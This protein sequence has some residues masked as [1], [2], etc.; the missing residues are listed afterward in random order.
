MQSRDFEPIAIIGMG[1]RFPGG[2]NSPEAFWDLLCKGT[3][4]IVD[5]PSDRWDVRRFY[6][7]DP[8]KPGKTYAKQGGFLRE[9]IDEFDPLFFGISPREAESM[10]PQQ[11]LLLEV[12][13]EA[14]EDA[15]V[16]AEKLEGSNTGVF[17]GGFCLDNKLLRFN[18][19]NLESIDMH[20]AA[21]SS[22]T[23]LSN[24]ISYIYDL[25]GPS[26]TIDTACSSSLVAT[27]YACHSIW[28]GE[29]EL[30]IA[31][32]AN[33]ML[34][35]EFG[36]VMSKGRFLSE[37]SRCMAFD[38]RA[39][40][41][42]RGE[43][44]GVVILKPL[45]SALTDRD[46][47]H[48][49]IRMSGVN[50]DGRTSGI[51]LPNALAQEELIRNV[52]RRAGISPAEVGYIEAHGTGTQVG[53]LSEITALNAA[54]SDDRDPGSKCFVGSVK[55]NIG[56]LE[57]A[58]G[59]AG[60]IKTVLCLKHRKIPPNLHFEQ[61]NPKIHFE[62]FC[63]HVP[64]RLEKWTLNSGSAYA[65]VNSF[66]YGGTNA[67]VVVEEAPRKNLKV[68]R[69][70]VGEIKTEIKGK[71]LSAE[72]SARSRTRDEAGGR[73]YL[74]P[75]SARS[76]QALQDLAGKYAFHLME[77][78]ETNLIEDIA[79]TASLKRTHFT[80][81]LAV[82]A[83]TGEELRNK[84][85]DFSSGEDIHGYVMGKAPPENQ[86]RLAS[87]YTGMGPQWWGM[88]REL[89]QAETVFRETFLKVDELFSELA[90]W[91]IIQAL[92]HN[93]S[94]SRISQTEV[95]QPANL[96]LQIALTALWKSWGITPDAVV[97]HSV[98]EVAAAY[99]AGALSLEDAV[100]VSFHRSRLQQTMAGRGAMLA[101]GLSERETREHI[102]KYADLSIA[103][104][105]SQS[106]VTVSGAPN[107]LKSLADTLE[108]NGAFHRSLKV[109]VAYHSY[110]MDALKEDF[111]LAL[112]GLT[113]R[114]A[115]FPL[116]STVTGGVVSGEELTSTYWWDNVRQPVRFQESIQSILGKGFRIFLEVGPHPVLGTSIKEVSA[117]ANSAVTT[118]PSLRRQTS[119]LDEI[120]NSLGG[121]FT[122]GFNIHWNTIAPENGTF[123]TL[124]TYA[125]Q[126]ERFW[127]ETSKSL[128]DRIG[129]NDSAF[130]NEKLG[131]PEPAWEVEVKILGASPEAFDIRL[132]ELETKQ[133]SGN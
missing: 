112:N 56:H 98:G 127:R 130:F 15:G 104:I 129:N 57:A 85:L 3:D 79:Y 73:S 13:W 41:Y 17:I 51:S 82:V 66:G 108:R 120:L 78:G 72:F 88:G 10:D 76:E 55:T 119:E 11:R 110:Q 44:A 63:V 80:H 121:L 125:W 21:S 47:I 114:K 61:P 6:D 36:I 23:I 39:T 14:F 29:S 102:R 12:T 42:T 122:R 54:L 7:P 109:E 34:K 53:D 70:H 19:L 43:G 48:A 8:D 111:L 94:S 100:L 52:Y 32:G 118:F 93:E 69:I 124:P 107:S 35:P 30:A 74:L 18:R 22:M 90:G 84:L 77:H 26:L 89:M 5:V 99:V 4:A 49:L 68:R 50:Q 81:R 1:C 37:H 20:T 97:G 60:L 105:N 28:S 91:S 86:R 25:K 16:I 59:I 9:K 132:Y 131:S 45:S 123:T 71:K 126:R 116:Y 67:H 33:V 46:P 113:A 96:A 103:A 95:A 128:E 27:H 24:R 83:K 64:T 115:E 92:G 38:E 31:G 101:I 87:V 40:G 62:K 106:A 75:I 2:A 133:A 117:E 58:A 65:G